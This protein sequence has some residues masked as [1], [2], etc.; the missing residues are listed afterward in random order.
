MQQTLPNLTRLSLTVAADP[1]HNEVEPSVVRPKNVQRGEE[2]E[3]RPPA[4]PGWKRRRNA[5]APQDVVRRPAMKAAEE[6]EAA[7]AD[8]KYKKAREK[9]TQQQGVLETLRNA[10]VPLQEKVSRVHSSYNELAI[11]FLSVLAD[12][13]NLQYF[14]DAIWY[15]RNPRL[16]MKWCELG[17]NINALGQSLI[18]EG[19]FRDD[20]GW[21]MKIDDTVTRGSILRVGKRG[22][23]FAARVGKV[24]RELK[25]LT[26]WFERAIHEQRNGAGGPE[27][28]ATGRGEFSYITEGP[29]HGPAT[30]PE[31]LSPTKETIA[32][33][34]EEDRWDVLKRKWASKEAESNV[35]ANNH[36]ETPGIFLVTNPYERGY[37]MYLG[38]VGVF[39]SRADARR[40][41]PSGRDEDACQYTENDLERN[42]SWVKETFFTQ[43]P[44]PKWYRGKNDTWI[45]GAHVNVTRIGVPKGKNPKYGI[46]LTDFNAG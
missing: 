16:V 18:T 25:A 4:P 34:D 24:V 15:N 14:S 2:E 7:G 39:R 30:K 45:H 46:I 3:F 10:K 42:E 11:S 13:G 31:D 22:E 8:E 28:R 41:H 36:K 43:G 27:Y 23:T 20:N 26:D 21:W 12:P 37:D 35:D 38:F 9:F 32:T 19:Y 29:A 5:S 44:A 6:Q 33:R 40:C 17:E 1:D